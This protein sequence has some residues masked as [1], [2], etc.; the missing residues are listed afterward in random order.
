[1]PLS[2]PTL[3]KYKKGNVFFETGTQYGGGIR[4]ALDAGFSKIISLEIDGAAVGRERGRYK[5][6]V[7][8]GQ[9]EIIHGDTAQIMG[10]VLAKIQE[11]VTFWLD[12]H[13]ESDHPQQFNGK[14][15]CP[16]YAELT[17]IMNHQIKTHT[18]MVDDMKIIGTNH[19]WGGTVAKDHIQHM[20]EAINADYKIE[21]VDGE[22]GPNQPDLQDILVASL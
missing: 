7:D 13:L 6:Q 19:F 5:V 20:I 1:M 15:H 9:V 22:Y 14:Q 3:K 17:F 21:I 10:D 11:P 4:M 18:I 16:L 2:L 12:A 8:S